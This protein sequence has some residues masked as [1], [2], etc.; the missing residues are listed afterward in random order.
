MAH[1]N[2]ATLVTPTVRGTALIYYQ[3]ARRDEEAQPGRNAQRD[4]DK[5][6]YDFEM[7]DIAG[8]RNPLEKRP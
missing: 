8:P 5:V 1:L 6:Y 3:P 2:P 7:N 4:K